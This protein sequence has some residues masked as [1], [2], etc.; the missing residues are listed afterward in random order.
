MSADAYKMAAARAAVELIEDGMKVGLGTGSTAGM[1]IDLLGERVRDGLDVICVPTSK[2]SEIQASNLGI[3]VTTLDEEP[4][5]DITVDGADEID[6]ELRLIKGGGGALLRE[7]IVAM[8]SDRMVVIADEG[9]VVDRLGKFPL[10]V[11]VD[12]F[13]LRATLEMIAA[14]SDELGLR[15]E[16]QVRETVEGKFFQTD[17]GHYIVD[18]YFEVINDPEELADCLAMLPGVV[19]S[20]LFIGIAERA[21]IGGSEGLTVLEASFDDDTEM[22]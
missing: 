13:G 4:F 17:G 18:C 3:A 10:P 15:Q 16:L 1:F 21:I 6:H 5:L 8:S 9:K 19:D 7:K 20:G 22:V 2:T 12:R 11:E 14:L